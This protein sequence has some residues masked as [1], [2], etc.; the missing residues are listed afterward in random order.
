M[1]TFLALC[2]VGQAISALLVWRFTW[3]LGRPALLDKEPRVVIVVAVKGHTVEFDEYVE[4]LFT[5]DYPNYRVI[6]AVEAD[7]DPVVAAIEKRRAA[8]PE[9]IKLIVA[10]F[11]VDEGQK[12]TNLCAALGATTPEDEILVLAD[13]D[14]WPERDWLRRLVEPINRGAADVV[15]AYPWIVVQDQI[16]RASCRE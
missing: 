4:N 16:G 5:Q 13:A 12:V 7:G 6:F 1:T 9:R 10:G 11:S 15:T 2:L 3:Q 8:D 14:I